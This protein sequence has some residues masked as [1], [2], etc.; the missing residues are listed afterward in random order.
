[1]LKGKTVK[2]ESVIF[3]KF[4]VAFTL[5][6]RFTDTYEVKICI[7]ENIIKIDYCHTIVL[8]AKFAAGGHFVGDITIKYFN[9]PSYNKAIVYEFFIIL[10]PS[11]IIGIISNLL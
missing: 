11:L 7:E 2:N 9:N 3:T 1:M 4:V 10:A 5:Y 6:L 8:R